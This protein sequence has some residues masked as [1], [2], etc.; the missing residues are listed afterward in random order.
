MLKYQ[1]ILSNTKIYFGNQIPSVFYD[2]VV[3][4]SSP[5]ATSQ[6]SH[7]AVSFGGQSSFTVCN[8]STPPPPFL[9]SKWLGEIPLWS[10]VK[11]S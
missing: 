11:L 1:A 5:D 2:P 6:S 8:N 4:S 3:S 10:I 7:K 9:K